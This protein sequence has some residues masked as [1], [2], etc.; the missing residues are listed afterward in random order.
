VYNLEVAND[1][2]Y[3]V[4]ELELW[5]HNTGGLERRMPFKTKQLRTS[6]PHDSE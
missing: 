1:H 4:G 6:H 3:F 5:V 2:S